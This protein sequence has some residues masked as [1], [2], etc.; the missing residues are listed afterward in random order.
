MKF[1]PLLENSW[2]P[3]TTPVT[4]TVEPIY[5]ILFECQHGKFYIE[6]KRLFETLKKG[7]KVRVCY[8]EVHRVVRNAEG[9]EV[10]R[11]LI[12]FD[13]LDAMPAEVEAAK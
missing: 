7:Q 12:K 10:S 2:Y 3:A 1:N 8:Q 9:K 4:V 11:E 5:G 6:R 13:F